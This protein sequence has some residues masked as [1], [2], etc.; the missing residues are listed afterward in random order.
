MHIEKY[1]YAYHDIVYNYIEYRANS[2][3]FFIKKLS[4]LIKGV[5]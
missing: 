5:Y 1:F 4:L 2:Y 3:Y